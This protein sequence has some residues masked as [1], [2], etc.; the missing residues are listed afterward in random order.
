MPRTTTKKTTK[1]EKIKEEQI[2]PAVEVAQDFPPA[3][4]AYGIAVAGGED[5]AEDDISK[6]ISKTIKETAGKPDRYF[7]AIGRR[8]TAVARVRLF[9]KG[10]KEFIVNSKPYQQYFQTTEDR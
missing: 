1:K 8:K 4:N 6:E 9:T 3:R 7:E 5:I 10:D 2:I